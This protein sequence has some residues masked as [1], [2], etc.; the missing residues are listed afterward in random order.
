MQVWIVDDDAGFAYQ[1]KH[2]IGAHTLFQKKDSSSKISVYLSGSEFL[3]ALSK[4]DAGPDLIFLDC[5]LGNDFGPEIYL[6]LDAP[7]Q[8]KICFC[9]SMSYGLFQEF[10]ISQN[11]PVPPFVPKRFV[12]QKWKKIVE[13]AY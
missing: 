5:Y 7:I 4:K 1:L 8:E 3:E 11:K 6:S 10:F 13:D 12:E 9:S 2:A